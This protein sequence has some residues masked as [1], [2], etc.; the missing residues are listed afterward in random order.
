MQEYHAGGERWCPEVSWSRGSSPGTQADT[1]LFYQLAPSG[2]FSL[3]TPRSSS[4]AF[5][6]QLS[7]V[8][9]SLPSGFG[10]LRRNSTSPNERAERYE[11][12]LAITGH[13]AR[14]GSLMVASSSSASWWI[15]SRKYFSYLAPSAAAKPKTE[16]GWLNCRDQSRFDESA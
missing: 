6:V 3:L 16:P 13:V 15:V 10:T 14:H 12:I 11:A 4:A 9:S 8:S 2:A 1:S 7:D 5:A